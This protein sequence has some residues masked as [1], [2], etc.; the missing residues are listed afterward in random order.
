MPSY[1]RWSSSNQ[2][3]RYNTLICMTKELIKCCRNGVGRGHVQ[4]M[5]QLLQQCILLVPTDFRQPGSAMK[6]KPPTRI[7]QACCA[8]LSYIPSIVAITVH[9]QYRM[10]LQL[11][12]NCFLQPFHIFHTGCTL[13]YR[14]I[15]HEI[16]LLWH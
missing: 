2:G 7:D 1:Q 8:D 11:L 4:D 13:S 12:S 5:D 9:V 15:S 10:V 14:R 6:L 16:S 3:M